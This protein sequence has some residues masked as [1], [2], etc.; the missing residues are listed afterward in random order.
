MDELKNL[1]GVP[2]SE[3][4][5][6]VG[7]ELSRIGLSAHIRGL[8][9]LLQKR[10]AHS[11]D[12]RDATME[13]VDPEVRVSRVGLIGFHKSCDSLLLLRMDDYWQIRVL[14][15]ISPKIIQELQDENGKM[16]TVDDPL[17]N[18]Q[19]SVRTLKAL[20]SFVTITAKHYGELA[21]PSAEVTKNL[22]LAT[23]KIHN[24]RYRK[25]K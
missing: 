23:L 3:A 11:D 6:Q 8:P 21:E 1:A 18:S 16:I 19:F 7:S 24:P 9:Q 20:R 14:L 4:I 10:F 25:P 15:S 17:T 5:I 12:Y 2:E 22:L 13:W